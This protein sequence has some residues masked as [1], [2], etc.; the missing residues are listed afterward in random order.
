MKCFGRWGVFLAKGIILTADSTC[1][2]GNEL[3]GKYQ[4]HYY[5]Y[6]IIL[7]DQQY[8]DNVDI[9]PD[10]LYR[11][12]REKKLLPKTAAISMTEYYDF[13]AGWVQDG[14]DVIHLN[15][16]SGIS[17][18]H[19]NCCLAAQSLGHVYVIDSCS[20]S[21]GTGHLV[22]EAAERIARGMPAQQIYEEITE[23]I[24]KVHASFILDTL[25]FMHA[26][27]RCSSVTALGA[28]LLKLKPCIEVSASGHGSMS[29][30][31][32]YRGDLDKVLRQ[33]I[34]DK[35]AAYPDIKTDRVFITHSGISEERIALVQDELQQHASFQETYITRASCTISCHCGPNTLG[36]L[37]MTK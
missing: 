6:H 32:K 34:R 29:V 31:K 20:L 19:Q 1:D 27:G 4:V 9:F 26:G 7:G 25:E 12:Y 8:T 36:I 30:G 14:Y 33:Y 35:L 15:L 11:A 5:P 17:A 3:K 28:N 24:P 13:F 16:G 10:D 22:I 18:A 23:L 2:L 21:T 37:F